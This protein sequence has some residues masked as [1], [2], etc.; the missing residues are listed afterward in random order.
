MRKKIDLGTRLVQEKRGD[1]AASTAPSILIETRT[2]PG[3]IMIAKL[4]TLAAFLLMVG[5]ASEKATKKDDA[6]NSEE[7][8]NAAY[9][10]LDKNVG[11]D[12]LQ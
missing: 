7:K 6:Q 2:K 4:L 12:T 10:E 8:A 1:C 3:G 11:K 5:C 9:Q